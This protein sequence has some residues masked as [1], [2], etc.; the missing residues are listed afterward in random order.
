MSTTQLDLFSVAIAPEATPDSPDDIFGL[1]IEDVEI[2]ESATSHMHRPKRER[3]ASTRRSPDRAEASLSMD[4]TRA[5]HQATWDAEHA[6]NELRA[7]NLE[8]S[9]DPMFNEPARRPTFTDVFGKVYT[10]RLM[11]NRDRAAFTRIGRQYSPRD[12]W[13]I[14]V[15]PREGIGQYGQ[16]PHTVYNTARTEA[17]AWG[18]IEGNDQHWRGMMQQWIDWTAASRAIPAGLSDDAL[19]AMYE[20][21]TTRYGRMTAES[22]IAL[23]ACEHEGR[24]SPHYNALSQHG[25]MLCAGGGGWHGGGACDHP[26]N[27]IPF[28]PL[29]AEA[30]IRREGSRHGRI[31]GAI[32][33]D[34]ESGHF[35]ATVT[36]AEGVEW[37]RPAVQA[38]STHSALRVDAQIAAGQ[39]ELFDDDGEDDEWSGDD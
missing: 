6:A 1:E 33:Y 32:V 14:E 18:Q 28:I 16:W 13:L 4:E 9:G 23:Y 24:W 5:A 36:L 39:V 27:G 12:K 22:Q 19:C 35:T 11:T 31:L 29:D 26:V 8:K 3:T 37:P 20:A 21:R 38:E 7:Q 17:L 30:W 10:C 25:A 2:Y 34:P 15:E